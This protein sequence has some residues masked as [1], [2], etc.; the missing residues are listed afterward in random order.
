MDCPICQEPMEEYKQET[1]HGSQE[2]EYRRTFYRCA[3]DDTWGR[4][5]VPLEIQLEVTLASSPS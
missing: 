5:E 4:T 1:S 2:K 3:K